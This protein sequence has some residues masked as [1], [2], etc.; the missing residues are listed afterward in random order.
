[1]FATVAVPAVLAIALIASLATLL[2]IKRYPAHS[3]VLCEGVF[4]DVYCHNYFC[5]KAE[6]LYCF[7]TPYRY[8]FRNEANEDLFYFEATCRLPIAADNLS[9]EYIPCSGQCIRLTANYNFFDKLISY[10]VERLA[11]WKPVTKVLEPLVFPD[12]PDF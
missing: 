1:M 11:D 8:R 5:E 12:Y 7:A 4:E 10:K 9:E 2:I 3:A 6:I